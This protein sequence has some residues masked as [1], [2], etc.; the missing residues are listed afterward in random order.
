MN[1]KGI[2]KIADN[3]LSMDRV[4]L[5]DIDAKTYGFPHQDITHIVLNSHADM[6]KVSQTLRRELIIDI[7]TGVRHPDRGIWGLFNPVSG[8]GF[9]S[10]A[11]TKEH[12]TLCEELY[13]TLAK[14]G[15]SVDLRKFLNLVGELACSYQLIPM[16]G[17]KD[18]PKVAIVGL[19]CNRGVGKHLDRLC[20]YA[21]LAE[22]VGDS[23]LRRDSVWPEDRS[24]IRGVTD[25][26][27][28]KVTKLRKN[29]GKK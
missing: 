22:T 26:K 28:W 20:S 2:A 14:Y 15:E 1:T 29:K 23:S 25:N 4:S 27:S 10:L 18:K 17:V 12:Y 19:G 8:Y 3:V 21:D 9:I 16:T 13:S 6:L 5:I 24:P 11:F 7:E